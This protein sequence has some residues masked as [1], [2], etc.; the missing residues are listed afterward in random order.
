MNKNNI[1]EYYPKTS[2]IV[3][4]ALDPLYKGHSPL[5]R[6]I[7][8][9]KEI[10]IMYRTPSNILPTLSKVCS[11]KSANQIK[12]NYESVYSIKFIQLFDNIN[13]R[14]RSYES[15]LKGKFTLYYVKRI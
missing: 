1:Y 6:I 14:I 10:S 7:A 3:L 12:I 15:R 9:G 4:W 11:F 13:F 2:F 8:R 5:Y